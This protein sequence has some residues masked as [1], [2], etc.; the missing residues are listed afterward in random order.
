MSKHLMECTGV[1]VLDTDTEYR[2]CF[3]HLNTMVYVR[4]FFIPWCHIMILIIIPN[5]PHTKYTCGGVI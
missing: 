5:T 3:L 1:Y 4:D 2:V